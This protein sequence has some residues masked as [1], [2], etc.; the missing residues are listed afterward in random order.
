MVLPLSFLTS[1][2]PSLLLGLLRSAPPHSTGAWVDWSVTWS[3]SPLR[4]F[5]SSSTVVAPELPLL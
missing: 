4:T 1:P 3:S 5:G 2:M